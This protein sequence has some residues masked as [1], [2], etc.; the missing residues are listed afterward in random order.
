MKPSKLPFNIQ[1]ERKYNEINTEDFLRDW[2]ENEEN[3]RDRTISMSNDLHIELVKF[4]TF[5]V[6]INE[7]IDIGL[8]YALS[9]REFRGM[10]AQ[11]IAYKSSY[12][13]H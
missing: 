11:L 9:K 5:E 8:R 3:R 1:L 2:I 7:I 6:D 13:T 10:I 12:L 4:G